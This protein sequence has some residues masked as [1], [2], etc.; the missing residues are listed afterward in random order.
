MEGGTR[1][2][3]DGRLAK[4]IGGEID[5]RSP[6]F[7]PMMTGGLRARQDAADKLR[8]TKVAA[9]GATRQMKR[10]ETTSHAAGAIREIRE[11][12]GRAFSACFLD[13]AAE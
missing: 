11:S 1:A 2:D 6:E 8:R 13:G 7:K 3:N 9:R 5:Y 12:A 4:R 10:K